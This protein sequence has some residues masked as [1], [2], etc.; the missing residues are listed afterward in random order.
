MNR[1]ILERIP[2]GFPEVM[3]AS[4]EVR[5]LEAGLLKCAKNSL[6]AGPGEVDSGGGN[7]E[8]DDFGLGIGPRNSD[9]LL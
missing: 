1:D 5:L 9:A 8:V 3:V 4:P 7:L 6:A 2:S